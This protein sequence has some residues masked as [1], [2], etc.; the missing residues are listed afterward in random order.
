MCLHKQGIHHIS[1]QRVEVPHHPYSK[2]LPYI[3]SNLPFSL[4]LF[5]LALS[6]QIRLKSLFP[7]KA[8]RYSFVNHS[9]FIILKHKVLCS[10]DTVSHLVYMYSKTRTNAAQKN[11]NTF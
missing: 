9:E 2:R 10:L 6:Q 7:V 4:K 3:Q 11:F 8:G 1:G 5:P